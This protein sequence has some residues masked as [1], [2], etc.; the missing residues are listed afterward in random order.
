VPGD[1]Q[2]DI[3][4]CHIAKYKP[5]VRE[6]QLDGARVWLDDK[7]IKAG[8]SIPQNIEE[9]LRHSR[10]SMFQSSALSN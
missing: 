10:V 2:F 8:E 7:Q 4:L 9:G 5:L 6:L 1:F 3:F